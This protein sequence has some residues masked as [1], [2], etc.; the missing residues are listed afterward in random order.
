M[1]LDWGE[2]ISLSHFYHNVLNNPLAY[3]LALLGA[4]IWAIYCNVTRRLAN[5]KNGI[6]IFFILTAVS[7][8][9]QYAATAQPNLVF[10]NVSLLYIIIAGVV[11]GSGYALWNIAIIGGN[12]MLL[13]TFSYFTPILS[14]LLST[15]ILGISL[16]ASFWQGV[17][18]VTIGS[19]MCWWVT[20]EKEK[21]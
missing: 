14:T 16:S 9:I 17:F 15:Y 3:G 12:M 13:A 19:L 6:V 2:E 5:G 11:M 8:W 10:S 21:R 7:L 4:V 1:E 20:K 18:L